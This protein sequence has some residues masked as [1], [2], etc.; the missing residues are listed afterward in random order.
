[1]YAKWYKIRSVKA[2]VTL[3]LTQDA[4]QKDVGLG[5]TTGYNN[6]EESFICGCA[7]LASGPAKQEFCWQRFFENTDVY[8]GDSGSADM[9]VLSWGDLFATLHTKDTKVGMIT[10]I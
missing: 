9:G 7:Y 4:Y 5:A 6:Y 3:F 10:R 2:H 1:M 8:R